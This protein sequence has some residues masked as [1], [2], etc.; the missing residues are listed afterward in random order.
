METY[1]MALNFAIPIFVALIVIE[2]IAAAR[3]NADVI[4]SMDT[5]AS[6]SSGLTNVIKDVLGLT[7]II[8]SY[9]WLVDKI[10]LFEIKSTIAVYVLA[11]VGKDFAGYWIHRLAHKVN[12]FWNHHIVHHSSEEF[13]LGCALRQSI[14][15]WFSITFIFL[16]PIALLGV[17]T[18]VVAIVGPLHLFAQYWYHTRLIGKLGWLERV[19]V[20]PSH[21]RVHHAI[22]EVYLDRNLSQVFIIWD[23]LFGTFQEEL[24]AV[25]PV[26]GVKRPVRTW[27][28]F[29]INFMHLWQLIKDAWHADKYW[30]KLRIWFMPTGWRPADVEVKFPLPVIEDEYAYQ[31]YDPKVSIQLQV[32]SWAQYVFIFAMTMYLFNRLAVIGIPGIFLY[33]FFLFLCVFAQTMLM[34]TNRYAWLVETTK[35]AIGLTVIVVTGDWFLLRDLSEGFLF[36]LS[37]YFLMSALIV[38]Y[39]HFTELKSTKAL[40]VA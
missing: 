30:D 3:M 20:T 9:A 39:F 15:E 1:V 7:I 19:I 13:N 14:S 5:L 31:K 32:W 8:I 10:A 33:G 18:K 17:P 40:Q 37:A 24:E 22:N 29:I 12:Y 4:R 38:N 28:P 34:D 27:N 16:I 23:K 25:A 11:F 6:L 35:S 21:H 36:A 26:Y 2:M